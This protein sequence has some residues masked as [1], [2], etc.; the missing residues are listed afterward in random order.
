[1][2]EKSSY[3]FEKLEELCKKYT[4][5]EKIKGKG[6]LIGIQFK[7]DTTEFVNKSFENGLLL[8]K[9]QGNV[10]RVIPALN[11]EKDDIDKAVEIMDKVLEEIKA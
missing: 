11:V 10:V 8:A 6:L 7:S 9:A 3:I 5:I 2:A 1:M 4:S